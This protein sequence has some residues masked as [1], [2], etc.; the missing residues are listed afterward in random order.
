MKYYGHSFPFYPSTVLI[1]LSEKQWKTPQ[2]NGWIALSSL[3][4]T[5]YTLVWWK[6]FCNMFF[7]LS[8]DIFFF[9]SLAHFSRKW[10]FISEI[11]WE[12]TRKTTQT[13]IQTK[14]KFRQFLT[15]FHNFNE[16]H[17]FLSILHVYQ[18]VCWCNEHQQIANER[19]ISQKLLWHLRK[20]CVEKVQPSYTTFN[21]VK[22]TAIKRRQKKKQLNISLL[23]LI[24][25]S[26]DG[27]ARGE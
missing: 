25:C 7:F 6:K 17:W 21:I 10:T 13:Y 4:F 24:F 19:A 23:I 27:H 2:E 18:S 11:N 16:I 1:E 14:I 8:F 15:F 3:S 5:L 12:W 26:F 22:L 20:M 9:F